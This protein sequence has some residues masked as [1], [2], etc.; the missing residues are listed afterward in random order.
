MEVDDSD[1]RESEQ[2]VGDDGDDTSLDSDSD[3]DEE[4]SMFEA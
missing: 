1:G 2:V 4:V 3:S